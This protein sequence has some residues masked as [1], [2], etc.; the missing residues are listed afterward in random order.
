MQDTGFVDVPVVDQWHITD[1]LSLR[2][3]SAAYSR[4]RVHGSHPLR[5]PHGL[6]VEGVER[7]PLLS[8]FHRP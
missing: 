7:H 1:D 6:S 3:R 2:R 4:P 5:A 8:E